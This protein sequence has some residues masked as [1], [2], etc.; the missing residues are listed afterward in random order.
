MMKEQ[1]TTEGKPFTRETLAE[2]LSVTPQTVAHYEQR[3]II[4]GF[5]MGRRILY[6]YEETINSIKNYQNR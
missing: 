2:Y 4:K 5:R 6:D 1:S 3:G